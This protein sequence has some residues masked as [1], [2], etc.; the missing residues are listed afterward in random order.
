VIG[1]IAD[2]PWA[3]DVVA[4]TVRQAVGL[5]DDGIEVRAEA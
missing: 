2:L 3:G 5:L 1:Q 4:D